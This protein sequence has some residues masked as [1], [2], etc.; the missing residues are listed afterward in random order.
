[1]K[2]VLVSLFC[3]ILVSNI[4][5]CQT[6]FLDPPF[7]FDLLEHIEYLQIYA[8][9]QNIVDSTIVDRLIEMPLLEYLHMDLGNGFDYMRPNIHHL[10]AKLKGLAIRGLYDPIDL[11]GARFEELSV[12]GKD[13][14]M[15]VVAGNL[16]SIEDLHSLRISF[17]S[18]TQT[19][20]LSIAEVNDLQRLLLIN[21]QNA[22]QVQGILT[23]LDSLKYLS[24]TGVTA[25]DLQ[26]VKSSIKHVDFTSKEGM[27]NEVLEA[28]GV[29]PYL[30]SIDLRISKNDTIVSA[31]MSLLH[32][33]K[34]LKLSGRLISIDESLGQLESLEKLNLRYLKLRDLPASLSN[35]SHLVELNVEG[36]NLTVL[37]DL[38]KMNNLIR[39]FC[40]NNKLQSLPKGIGSLKMLKELHASG[41]QLSVLPDD[42]GELKSLEVLNL[43]NNHLRFLPKSFTALNKLKILNLSTNCMQEL[44]EDIG[45]LESL[46]DLRLFSKKARNIDGRKG[47]GLE[48]KNDLKEIPKSIVSCKELVQLLLSGAGVFDEVDV[49]R[50]LNIPNDKLKINMRECGI[51]K[52]S[53]D[54]WLDS[55]VAFIDLSKNQISDIPKEILMSNIPEINLKKNNLGI[56]GQ[57]Y[58]SEALKF[59]VMYDKGLVSK[60]DVLEYQGMKEAIVKVC[61]RFYYDNEN[62]PILKFLPIAMEIDPEYVENNIDTENYAEALLDAERYNDAIDYYTQTIDRQMSRGIKFANSIALNIQNRHKAYLAIGDT[63]SAIDDLKLIQSEFNYD[64]NSDIF[65][66]LIESGK[67][68]LAKE[69]VSPTIAYYQELID[70]NKSNEE[71]LILSMME[72]YLVTD[73][74]L[75]FDKLYRDNYSRVWK[76][77]YAELFEYLHLVRDI[78]TKEMNENDADAINEF[79]YRLEKNKFTNSS[80]SCGLVA[81]YSEQFS[82]TKKNYIRDLNQVICQ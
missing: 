34:S 70:K 56:Y 24:L 61:S 59:L 8:W 35:L 13:S 75:A 46:E 23:E 11:T 36:N 60:K 77:S 58:D 76:S 7:P 79:V 47:G 80:W 63:L 12:S 42:I 57:K 48:C 16:K 52:L 43:N 25:A 64:M 54:G 53:S 19:S 18:L 26:N 14:L 72:V 67:F 33:L 45:K 62:N 69:Y 39:L 41:N 20:A 2:K 29:L 31:D 27:H 49:K 6:T 74:L 65:S 82:D 50:V 40:R 17:D 5:R 10:W 22:G 3:V 68:E 55:K 4:A 51:N 9:N 78:S 1:M 73:D 81:S 32:S 66:L 28:L 30:E 15:H 44:P 38:S 37:P 71:G 21:K